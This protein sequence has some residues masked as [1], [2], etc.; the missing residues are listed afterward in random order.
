MTWIEKDEIRQK[1]FS[2]VGFAK[3]QLLGVTAWRSRA[4]ALSI[5]GLGG[6]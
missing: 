1:K 6:R 2:Q 4:Q 3:Q 5:L